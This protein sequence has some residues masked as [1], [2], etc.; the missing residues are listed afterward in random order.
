MAREDASSI[1]IIG[2]GVQARTQ[3]AAVCAVRPIRT[4]R[5]YSRNPERRD[6]A[7]AQ[8]TTRNFQRAKAQSR[9]QAR[10]FL[11]RAAQANTSAA[12]AFGGALSTGFTVDQA[13]RADFMNAIGTAT[14]GVNKAIDLFG[15]NVST[16]QARSDA[17]N[18]GRPAGDPMF[19]YPSF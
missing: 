11:T 13:N 18:G 7:I 8:V 5:A 6:E 19:N 16:A 15:S 12:G 4:V 3:L 17:S 14:S 10:A 2:T 1:G 9:E